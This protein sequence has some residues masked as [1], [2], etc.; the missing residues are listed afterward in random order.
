M[1][2]RVERRAV[3]PFLLQR[4]VLLHEVERHVPGAFHHHLNVVLPRAL[5]QFSEGAQL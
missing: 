1:A 4:N 5:G 2:E 3:A